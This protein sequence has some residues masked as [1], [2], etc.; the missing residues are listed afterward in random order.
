MIAMDHP[1]HDLT[2]HSWGLKLR[3][4]PT[5]SILDTAS[6][7]IAVISIPISSHLWTIDEFHFCPFWSWYTPSLPDTFKPCSTFCYS[8]HRAL[9]RRCALAYTT[10]T[11]KC[12]ATL[13][14]FPWNITLLGASP[15]VAFLPEHDHT[16]SLSFRPWDAGIQFLRS[17]ASAFHV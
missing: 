4:Q 9:R 2:K 14:S 10:H 12:I 3:V 5:S 6:R 13:L 11:T 15:W 8:K 17:M 1:W 16:I 7:S